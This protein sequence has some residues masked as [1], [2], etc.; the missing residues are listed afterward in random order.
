MLSGISFLFHKLIY[1]FQIRLPYHLALV[2]GIPFI[3]LFK[4]L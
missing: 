4:T 1:V 3:L 2:A